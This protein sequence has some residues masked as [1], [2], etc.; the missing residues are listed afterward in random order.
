MQNKRGK[1]T[2][3]IRDKA[4]KKLAQSSE[5]MT[6]IN[7]DTPEKLVHE[8]QIH[9]IELEMQ[10]EELRNARLASDESRNKYIDLYDFAPIGYFTFT[11]DAV[12]KEVNLTGASLLGIERKKLV[13]TRFTCFIAP[14]FL[15]KWDRYLINMFMTGE[16]Y[17]CELQIKR[18]D[19]SMF[20]AQLESI[21]MVMDG[22]LMV[23][24]MVSDITERI[25]DEQERERLIAELREALA[26]V[27]TLRG[28]IPICS[29]C[30]KIKDDKGYW[31]QVADYMSQHSEAEFSH[32]ACPECYEK[33]MKELE[34]IKKA[35]S[36][37]SNLLCSHLEPLEKY[38]LN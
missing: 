17:I 12:I 32:G 26:N 10:N 27:K 5:S 34:G 8:L 21:R 2:R 38:Q 3:S 30:K 28:M 25:K 9:Q 7:E 1:A 15:G 23:R 31:Q 35:R 24:T 13:N 14:E 22:A 16:K 36:L 4:E 19:D 6:K 37:V 11:R 20:K 33:A 29:Y 18:K